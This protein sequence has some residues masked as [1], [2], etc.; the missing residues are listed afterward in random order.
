MGNIE[1][2]ASA[3]LNAQADHEGEKMNLTVNSKKTVIVDKESLS[4]SGLLGELDVSD[5]LYVTVE[6][7]G[8]IMERINFGNILV[9]DGDEIEFL[10]FMGGGRGKC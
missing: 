9:R 3:S 7:N 1:N 2:S 6:L 8:D 10:Y 4:I 5:P